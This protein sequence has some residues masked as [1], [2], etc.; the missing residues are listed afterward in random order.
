MPEATGIHVVLDAR[1]FKINLTKCKRFF[2]KLT[3]CE[4]PD[5]RDLLF[6]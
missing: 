5:C 6:F 4:G 1:R 2:D 3:F